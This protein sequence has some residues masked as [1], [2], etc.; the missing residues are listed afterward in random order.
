MSDIP[1]VLT[2]AGRTNQAPVVLLNQLLD[3][4][5]STNPGYTAHLPGSLIEDISSTDVGALT[6]QDQFVTELIN[7]ISPFTANAWLLFQL[8]Q[9]YGIQPGKTT[10]N[11]VYVVFSGTIG[12][13][14][15]KGF[16][17]SD[18]T[19][20]YTVQDSGVIGASGSSLPLYCVATQQG[21]WSIPAN[22]VN[23]LITSVPSTI[24]LSC[25]NPAVG[26]TSTG[27]ETEANYRALVLQAGQA[28]ATGMPT[29]LKTLLN[30]IPG[31][32]NRLIAVQPQTGGGW[33]ILVGGGDPYYVADA[34]YK[35]IFDVSIL[36][37][38]KTFISGVTNANPGVVTTTINHGLVTGQGGV[39]IADVVGMTG[40][41][42][43]PYTVTVID[44]KTFSFGVDTTSS[45]SYVSGGIVTPNTRNIDVSIVDYPDTYPIVF[46]NPPQQEVAISVTW[47][48]NSTNIVA[49][50]AVSQAA[51]PALIAYINSIFVG[52]PIN[53]FEL[54]AVFQAAI[55][56]I[57]PPA[58]LTRMVFDVSINGVGT[59]P[60][61]GTGIIAGDA[62]SYF[63]TNTALI[64]VTQG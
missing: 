38:S 9:I 4:V 3:L 26:T 33:K 42:G 19:Y 5:A 61:A 56:N 30:N 11:S 2:Q 37:G 63:E 41:N 40:V 62:E 25:N 22:V 55:A 31:V 52:Q 12:F 48:T 32:Q 21:T 20:Q 18:G 28:I 10:N 6:I 27:G 46:V 34:I 43:G 17:V 14:I 47:N 64:T 29:F 24:T 59:P 60:E 15:V 1:I 57:I 39:H 36:V 35:A 23:Q 58:Q 49:P 50:A 45:G 51:E 7:S 53:L 13:V 16:T 54:Q 44:E 8:G